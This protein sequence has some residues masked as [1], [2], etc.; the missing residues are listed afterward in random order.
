MRRSILAACVCLLLGC[1]SNVSKP[2]PKDAKSE[3]RADADAKTDAKVDAKRDADA[4]ANDAPS[5]TDA[6]APDD[7]PSEAAAELLPDAPLPIADILGK[8]PAEAQAK[9]G[10][11]TGKGMQRTS[12]VRFL[13]ERVWFECSYAH[14]RY[15]DTT[16][17][18]KAVQVSYEDGKAAAV[19]FEGVPGEG[20]FDPIA[21]LAKVG[22]KL[23]G[24]PRESSPN[25]GVKL[26]SWFN[27]D[28]R[29]VLGGLQYRVEVSTIDDKWENAKVEIILNHPLDE[30]QQAKIKDVRGKSG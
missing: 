5:P 2:G 3:K 27:S 14:Q 30:A 25:E 19:A 20:A 13:P 8:P 4:A 17:T 22:L 11:P 21:A 6:K 10:E 26:W 29:L 15:N 9:L 16:G 23:P 24:T 12:C 28:A 18:Y 7:R 1:P